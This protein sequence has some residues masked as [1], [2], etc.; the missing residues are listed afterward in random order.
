LSERII[1]LLV[2]QRAPET[3]QLLYVALFDQ[4]RAAENVVVR[5]LMDIGTRQ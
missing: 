3:I 4:L 2:V 5:E 1:P